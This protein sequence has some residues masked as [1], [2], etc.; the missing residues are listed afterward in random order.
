MI[1]RAKLLVVH[2]RPKGKSLVFGPGEYLF[3][4]GDE[5]H[6]RPNSDWVSRQH[7]L[8]RVAPDGVFLRDLG[9]RNGTLVNG[10]RVVDECPLQQGDHVQVG[11]LVFQVK[12]EDVLTT[13]VPEGA[14]TMDIRGETDT[15]NKGTA[16]FPI[17][18][19]LEADP[20][21][22]PLAPPDLNDTL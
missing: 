10:K 11:P 18:N 17:M 1:K 21:D 8:L 19:P 15:P 9:S 6:V 3:G 22:P 5:C 12:I 2:G 20:D 13:T 7:C 14:S 4:R 16:E